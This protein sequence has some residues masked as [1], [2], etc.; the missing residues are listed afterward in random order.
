MQRG[1]G[2]K[3]FL[4]YIRRNPA[5][6]L[7][8]LIL[9]ALLLF[10]TV[11]GYFVPKE[12]AYPLYAKPKQKPSSE[13]PFGTDSVG[14]DLLPTLIYGTRMTLS[15]GMIAGCIGLGVGTVLGFMTGYFGGLFDTIVKFLVD[16]L[17]TIPSFLLLITI[18][19]SVPNPEEMSV[20]QMALILS[21]VSWVQPTRAIRAQVLSMRERAFVMMAKLSGMSGMEI[22][23]KELMPNLMPYLAISLAGAV[24]GGVL[25]S[26]GLQTLGIGNLREPSLGMTIYWL[27]YYNAFLQGYWWWIIEPVIVIAAIFIAFLLIS[28]GLDEFANPR[29]RRTV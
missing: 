23:I 3:G 26:L 4:N 29:T 19:A 17:M 7:G 20:L 22:I 18:S 5:L 10:S 9:L 21:L 2:F 11:A 27:R 24:N 6:G 16:V 12:G 13:Y 1:Q 8:L 15:I 25:G 28:I 14:R